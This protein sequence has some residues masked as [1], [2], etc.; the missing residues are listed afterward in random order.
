MKKTVQGRNHHAFSDDPQR[1]Y[2]SD[3]GCHCQ[4]CQPEI[5]QYV[6]QTFGYDLNRTC[7]E[8]RPNYHHVETCQ[9]T[10]PEAIDARRKMRYTLLEVMHN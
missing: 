7:D 10:V 6:E 4:P 5:Q 9:E 8:I 2:Q 1:H 3:S